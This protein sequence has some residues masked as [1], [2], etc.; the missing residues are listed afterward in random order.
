LNKGIDWELSPNYTFDIPDGIVLELNIL[1]QNFRSIIYV[2]KISVLSFSSLFYIDE[3]IITLKVLFKSTFEKIQNKEIYKIYKYY[4][5]I[6]IKLKAI[7]V[8][9][10][11]CLDRNC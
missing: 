10:L 6:N 4:K 5:F 11:S 3:V 2:L 7:G 8:K 1:S 9:W